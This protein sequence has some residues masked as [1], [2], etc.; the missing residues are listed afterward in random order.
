V[1]DHP[2]DGGSPT[3]AGPDAEATVGP[4]GDAV[5]VPTDDATTS[6]SRPDPTSAAAAVAATAPGIDPRRATR[7][8][9]RVPSWLATLS[10]WMWRAIVVIAGS[11]LLLAAAMRLGLV[12]IPI[13]VALILSTFLVP[14]ARWLES[15]GLPRAPAALIVVLGGIGLFVG[16]FALLA[17]AFVEEVQE[18]GPTVTEGLEDLFA[19]TD[20]TFGYDQEAVLDLVNQ[21]MQQLQGQTGQLA[22]QLAAAGG[23]I[24]QGITALALALV[25]LFFFVKDGE[26]IVA[27]ILERSP[28]TH[29]DTVRAAG[30]RA[31]VALSGF[32]RGTAL[33]ALVDA[34]GIGVGLAILGV[35]LVLPIM[36]LTFFGGFIP[37]VGAFIAGLIAVLVALAATGEIVTALI[38]L[39]IV[40][41]VQQFESNVLQP[42][43][44]RRAV[45]LHPVVILAALTAGGLLLGIIGAFLAVPVAAVV[46][47]V[48]NELRLRHEAARSG[49]TLVQ[50]EPDPLGPEHAPADPDHL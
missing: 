5:D 33:V 27:W 2:R 47:A 20:R 31:W 11:A 18:L 38:V 48:G 39:A 4:A 40:V 35:P 6:P 23:A 3:T 7:E 30:R 19:F 28:D 34:I 12:T 50:G 41:G 32:I 13:I 46:S 14:P 36:V 37:V 45:S 1:N 24:V 16:V 21:G 8:I 17:P 9:E 10:A 22:G 42:V 43:I 44:M 29:R 15:K 49:D 26:Q 25:L